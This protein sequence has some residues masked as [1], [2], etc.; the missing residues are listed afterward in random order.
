MTR[1]LLR[2]LG[3]TLLVLL[4]VS[5]IIFA[6]L[7][8]IP[9]DAAEA[10]V[11]ES[12]SQ[13][14]LDALRHEMGLDVPLVPRY[15]AFLSGLLTRGELGRSL[16]S[17]RQI[18][19][20]LADSF[21]YTLL[22]ALIATALGT[23]AGMLIGTLAATHSGGYL[24]TIIMGTTALGQAVPTFWSALLLILLFSLALGWLP[25][26][27]ASSPKHL[28]LPAITLAVPMAAVVARL[29]RSSILEELNAYYV[30]TA[31]AK[32]ASSRRVMLGHV[33]R[34]SLIPVINLLGLYLGR[35]LG[36]AFIVE[37]IFGWPGLGRLTVQAI[38]DRDLPVVLGAALTIATMFLII[39]FLVDLGHAWLDPR[40]AH[41]AV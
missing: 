39:N 9:G 4:A 11:G 2:R 38:F 15:L 13:E 40:V 12:A 41:E 23:I 25:V 37:T 34:N 36:G 35:L 10:M 33:F 6:A 20:L 21:P 16:I 8:V 18:T 17:G 7:D 30:L 28:V 5:F 3:G 14:Q 27:G 31:R 26:V 1:H 29:M 24:D 22:L 19:G 32:G